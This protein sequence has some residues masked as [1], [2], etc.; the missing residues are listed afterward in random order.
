MTHYITIGGQ[1][2][3]IRFGYKAIKAISKKLKLKLGDFQQIMDSFENIEVLAYYGFINGAES[4]G[5]KVDFNLKDIADWLDLDGM[6]KIQEIL[7]VFGES[8]SETETDETPT[9]GKP[10]LQTTT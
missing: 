3:P 10:K 9:E 6:G 7:T 2:R 5:Q 4:V 8:Q 1:E